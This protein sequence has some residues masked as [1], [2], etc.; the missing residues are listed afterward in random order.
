MPRATS[1]NAFDRP[2]KIR[3]VNK[4]YFFALE[5]IKTE[6][7]YIKG[8]FSSDKINESIFYFYRNK[9]HPESS[10]LLNITKSVMSVIEGSESINLMY[11]DLFEIFYGICVCKKLV[12]PR[13]KLRS[14]I[15]SFVSSI[16]ANMHSEIKEE[17]IP[18]L[19]ARLN[20]G[21]L[22]DSIDEP[23]ISELKGLIKEQSTYDPSIDEIIIIGDRDRQ[24]FTDTQYDEV[25]E[26]IA[27]ENVIL[28]ISNPC[29][30]FWFLLHYTDCKDID[31]TDWN[32]AKDAAE[33][34]IKEL[35]VFDKKYKKNAIDV[36]KYLGKSSMAVKNSQ[37]Y[38]TTALALKDKIGSNM[39]DLIALV[40]RIKEEQSKNA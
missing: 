7:D 38:A 9:Q 4:K 18:S 25:L 1:I 23:M 20:S 3:E 19:M 14:K 2:S 36:N 5:G 10:N 29:I 6:V 12:V 40:K 21:I 39:A 37:N 34:V 28:I 32:I 11:N 15:E 33:R 17:A 27:G 8:L 31:K 30:E 13:D 24:S 26:R 22:N 35:K 16:G